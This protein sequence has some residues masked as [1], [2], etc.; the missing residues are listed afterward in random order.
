MYLFFSIN[1]DKPEHVFELNP[2]FKDRFFIVFVK[3]VFIGT[4]EGEISFVVIG[5]CIT[6]CCMW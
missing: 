4:S 5:N 2:I 6:S 3:E 1:K